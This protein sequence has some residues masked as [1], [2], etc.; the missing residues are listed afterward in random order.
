MAGRVRAGSGFVLLS[1]VAGLS[2]VPDA[3]SSRLTIVHTN[4]LQSRLEGFAPDADYTPLSLNDDATVGGLARVATVIRSVRDRAPDRTLVLDG[5]DIFMGT[6]FHTLARETGAELRLL[7]EIGYDAAVLG[8][9]EF[10]FRPAGLARILQSGLRDG[11]IPALLL[12][13]IRFD[14]DSPADDELQGLF[15]QGVV[16]DRL[17]I[18][19]AGLRIG[20]FGLMGLDAAEV[21]APYARPVGFDDP[22]PVARRM[23]ERLRNEEKA[24]LVIC[25]SHGGV[26]RPPGAESW[27]GEDVELARQAPGIDV[28]VGGHSHTPLFEPVLVGGTPVVQAG[29]EGRFVGVLE[30]EIE[31]G[32]RRVLDYKLIPIDDSIEAARDIHEKVEAHKRR[33]EEQVLRPL[34]LAFDQIVLETGFDLVLDQPARLAESNL[35]PFAADAIRRGLELAAGGPRG[36]AT[37]VALTTA[38]VLRDSLRRGRRGLQQAS[39]LFRVVPLGI[40]SVDDRVGVPLARI[41]VNASEL[42]SILEILCLAHEAKGSSYYPYL[43]GLRFG[44]NPYRVPLDRVFEIELG[45]EV[46]GYAPLDLSASNTRLYSL[47]LSLYLLKFVG[48]IEQ[49]SHGL[50][51]VTPKDAQGRPIRSPEEALLDADP[52][53]PGVQELKEWIAVLTAVRQLPDTDGD[54]IPDVPERYSRA[55]ARMVAEPSLHPAL[56]FRNAAWPMGAAGLG[57][58]LAAAG[59]LAAV[60]RLLRRRR[61][62]AAMR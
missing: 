32:K 31:A 56:L 38:G 34:G 46:S 14:P 4:D 16:R 52:Q 20:L 21:E 5:G 44:Y 35:G 2:S 39:D 8:N 23:A 12:S 36:P 33:V 58:L 7:H 60:R 9:H 53:A 57:A 41:Y 26:R 62:R 19:R 48:L 40:G 17:V 25:L 30:L 24:D 22:V 13:N 59:L 28:L 18:E 1:V 50:L 61:R 37:D 55:L 29:S 54:G 3:I 11:P 42:R 47:G 10:D 43:S 15:E 27:G 6:L 51:A 45:D 49:L